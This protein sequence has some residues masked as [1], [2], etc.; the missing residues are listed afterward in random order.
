MQLVLKTCRKPEGLQSKEEVEE[1]YKTELQTYFWHYAYEK[2]GLMYFFLSKPAPSLYGKRTGIAGSFK[3]Q[4]R[5]SIKSYRE[6]F[7][8]FKLSPSELEERG[9]ILFE[10]MVN[11]KDLTGYQPGGKECKNKEWIEFPDKMNYYDESAQS[12]K[13]QDNP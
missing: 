3:S 12:W 4:D 11:G 9:R 2:G 5:M 10:K 8:T 1:Y 7:R 13:I 6:V